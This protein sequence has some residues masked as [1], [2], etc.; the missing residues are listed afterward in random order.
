MPLS[1]LV[2]FP[3]GFFI[4]LARRQF[5]PTTL[6]RFLSDLR[7][8]IKNVRVAS[9]CKSKNLMKFFFEII[10]LPTYYYLMLSVTKSFY[11]IFYHSIVAATRVICLPASCIYNYRHIHVH[12]IDALKYV[13][14]V[15][16]DGY[17]LCICL[18]V[19]INMYTFQLIYSFAQ[20][21]F[22]RT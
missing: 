20:F 13:K 10:F 3:I 5:P 22:N 11:V 9:I 15:H 7:N 19:F 2:I 6:T 12:E 14:N 21:E 17:V 18:Y 1:S 4:G 8:F 16:M